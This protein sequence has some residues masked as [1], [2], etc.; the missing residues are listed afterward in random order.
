M[1]V[2]ILQLRK[3]ETSKH[4][5][6]LLT[7]F[8]CLVSGVSAA[9]CD[10]SILPIASPRELAYQN[11]GDRCEGLY[12]Q[13]VATTGLRILGFFRGA[14]EIREGDAMPYVFASYPGVK[15]LSVESIRRRQYYRMDA[16][17]D[18]DRFRYPFDLI[19]RPELAIDINDLALR[20]CVDACDG[21]LPVLVPT[22]L[23]SE[24]SFADRPY[25]VLRATEDLTYL[26]IEIIGQ[27]RAVLYDQNILASTNWDA[28][29]PVEVP[30]R[31]FMKSSGDL[32][33]RATAQGRSARQLDSVAAILRFAAP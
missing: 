10:R 4:F 19:R 5:F 11:R 15:F 18:T 21:L 13:P 20:L 1:I 27:E 26:R 6:M 8:L 33:F 30:L 14:S 25:L 12:Q 2:A 17:F 22:R 24:N 23:A 3:L 9:E 16:S 28:W 7:A 29:R 31:D 32:L